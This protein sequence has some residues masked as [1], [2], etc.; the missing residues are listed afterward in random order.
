MLTTAKRGTVWRIKYVDSAGAQIMETLGS[1]RHG[2][3]RKK[4]EAE[5]RE[6]LVRVERKNYPAS[7]AAH[8]RP[9]R[10]PRSFASRSRS[11]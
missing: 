8:V 9:R 7:E 3:T 4:A 6:R 2:W 5:L 10:P 11:E 1:E